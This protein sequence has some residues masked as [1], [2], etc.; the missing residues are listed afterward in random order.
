[1]GQEQDINL[2]SIFEINMMVLN[3]IRTQPSEDVIALLRIDN[4]IIEVIKQ[5]SSCQ[6]L[7]LTETNQLLIKLK[8]ETIDDFIK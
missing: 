8:D 6:L 2:K 1:M 7:K 3:F 5:M 4:N